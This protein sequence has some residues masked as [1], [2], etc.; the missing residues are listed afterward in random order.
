V[1]LTA[2]NARALGRTGVRAVAPD[3]VPDAV[4]FA[5]I[6]SNPPIRVGKA[7]LHEL[8]LR[9]LPRLDAGGTAHLVVQRNLGA[10][11]LHR[12]LQEQGWDVQR[13]ASARGYRVLAVRPAAA[14]GS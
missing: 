11:S 8:L 9:W 10:D 6:W 3:E 13:A 14:D 7:A 1:D 2:A 5:A 4:R 12:W